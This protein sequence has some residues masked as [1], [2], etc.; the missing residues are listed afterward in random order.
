MH[1][2]FIYRNLKTKEM[3]KGLFECDVGESWLDPRC[4]SSKFHNKQNR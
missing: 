4:N 3:T 1:I 2:N